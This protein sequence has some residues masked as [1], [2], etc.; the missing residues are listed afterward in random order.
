[1]K[2]FLIIFIWFI[3]IYLV[4]L[5]QSERDFS[6]YTKSLLPKHYQVEITK[7][8]ADT[9]TT[10]Y[11]LNLSDKSNFTIEAYIKRP[12]NE[13]KLS[14]VLLLGGMLTG[15]RAVEYAYDVENVIIIA[16]DYPYKFRK[17]YSFFEI[18][19]DLDRAH[20]SLHYQIRDNLVL[21][22]FLR[23][24]KYVDKEKIGILGYSFG[25]PFAL[26]TTGI[27]PNIQNIALVYGGADIKL[28]ID[29]NLSVYN[30]IID[31]VLVYFFWMHLS[32]FEPS[33]HAK[34]IE[35]MPLI[36]INGEIDEKIPKI[37]AIE[38]QE[39]F[40]F[41]KDVKWLPSKHVHPRN[42]NLSMEIIRLLKDWYQKIGFV[43]L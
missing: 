14:T 37:S 4:F 41:E 32:D 43:G 27:D 10:I 34:K 26:A 1:M 22:E 18:I 2:V 20:R 16:P 29:T 31:K 35:Q 25:V 7:I 36:L 3:Y 8:K 13:E 12:N 33:R 17:K 5:L 40:K 38:L 24:W 6:R 28:L 39:C 11:Q 23:N 21:L 15:K 19:W 42:I 30:A 9:T